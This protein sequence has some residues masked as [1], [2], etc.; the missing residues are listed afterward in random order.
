MD[1]SFK[2]EGV[3][4]RNSLAYFPLQILK[5]GVCHIFVSKPIRGNRIY[6][7]DWF[8]PIK[9]HPS[10]NHIAKWNRAI[11]QSD[12]VLLGS[13]EGNGYCIGSQLFKLNYLRA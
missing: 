9:S 5:T 10:L 2:N 8:R 11:P 13:R 7:H 3:F 4:P 6:Y 12:Q 1:A